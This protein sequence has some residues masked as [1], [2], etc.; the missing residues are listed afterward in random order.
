MTVRCGVCAASAPTKAFEALAPLR[1][2]DAALRRETNDSLNLRAKG[3]GRVPHT[4]VTEKEHGLFL[5]SVS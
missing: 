2:S 1:K 5:G 4:R 3:E